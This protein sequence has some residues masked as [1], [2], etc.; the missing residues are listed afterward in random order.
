MSQLP[1]RGNVEFY[2]INEHEKRVEQ[3][4]RQIS[5]FAA[6]DLSAHKHLWHMLGR[7]PYARFAGHVFFAEMIRLIAPQ[8]DNCVVTVRRRL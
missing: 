1:T 2:E 4:C 8:T 7:F 6:S 3:L 5:N